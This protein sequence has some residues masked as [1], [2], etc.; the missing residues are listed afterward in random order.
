MNRKEAIL[1]TTV[2]LAT[3]VGGAFADMISTAP[4]RMSLQT[5]SADIEVLNIPPG[6]WA[7]GNQANGVLVCNICPEISN[8]SAGFAFAPARGFVEVKSVLLTLTYHSLTAPGPRDFS[9]RLNGNLPS[10]VHMLSSYV[11]Y[12]TVVPLS[13]HD[14]RV[15]VNVI[16]IGALGDQIQA[17]VFEVRLT[18]E[19]TFLA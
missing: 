6:S 9:I 17:Q 3:F 14:L 10:L 19:Y 7:G 11:P 5:T 12:A 16:D 4:T 13:P 1:V 8:V 2:L 18:V 15:G